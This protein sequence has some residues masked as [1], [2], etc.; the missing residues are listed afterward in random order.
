[1]VIVGEKEKLDLEV[2]RMTEERTTKDQQLGKYCAVWLKVYKTRKTGCAI[3][4]D[5][6]CYRGNLKET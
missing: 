4:I 3:A 1:M 2:K 6:C 5:Y